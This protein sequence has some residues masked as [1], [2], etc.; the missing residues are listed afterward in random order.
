MFPSSPSSKEGGEYQDSP[1]NSTSLPYTVKALRHLRKADLSLVPIFD[2]VG[3]F[4][5]NLVSDRFTALIRAIVGQQISVKAAQSIYDRLVN[6]LPNQALSPASLSDL[7]HEN[8]RSVG[9]SK[10]K[11]TYVHDLSEKVST[12]AVD[13]ENI[14]D[15]DDE[16]VIAALIPV[17]GIGRW[18]AEMFLFFSLGRPDVLPVDDLGL[19]AGVQR[20]D[21]LEELPTKMAVKERGAAWAPFRSVATWYLWQSLKPEN[22][23]S[24]VTVQKV[25]K[26]KRA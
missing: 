19:R 1:M 13:L 24:A 2:R 18:T 10:A 11:A 4:R 15:L 12:R 16:G 26:R 5:P 8:L 23:L 21:G 3:P 9:L 14:H 7:S 22:A 6:L 20:L 17:K 25:E